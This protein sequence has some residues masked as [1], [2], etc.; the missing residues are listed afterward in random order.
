M[1][2]FTSTVLADRFAKAIDSED[3]IELF[4]GLFLDSTNTVL[5]G[6]GQEP[7][8]IPADT[9]FLHHRIIFSHDYSASALHEIAHWC[10]AGEARR[11]IVDYG[12]WYVPDGRNE[13]EQ[14][15]FEQ[16]E[17]K[18]QALEWLFSE[19]CGL[20]FRVSADNLDG[21]AAPSLNF[22]RNIAKQ[23]QN[24]C[25]G[26]LNE[27]AKAWLGVLIKHYQSGQILESS[28]YCVTHLG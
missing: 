6:G 26:G 11:K 16:V 1:D 15:A 23:A 17:V 20:R 10:V 18:P 2:T 27:R 21:G 12:Y 14:N 22:K 13:S 28:R 25:V 24:Y 7:E 8:Y 3:L 4:N 5:M 19:A 9:S